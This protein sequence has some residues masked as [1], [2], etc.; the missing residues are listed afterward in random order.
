MNAI[1]KKCG[2][3][4]G[5][6]VEHKWWRRYT[7]GGFFSRGTGEYWI[8]DGSL[9]FEHHASQQTISLPLHKLSEIKVCPCRG[10]AGGIPIIKLVWEKDGR[11]LSSSFILSG[12]VDKSSNLLT[13][14][15][16]EGLRS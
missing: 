1:Q 3:Y 2:Q 14:L 12:L 6:R 4:L 16:S 5:T 8:K 7:E 10:R 15:R 13:S 11:W 9:F